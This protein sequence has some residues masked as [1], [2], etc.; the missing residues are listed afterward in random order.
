MK[1]EQ[2]KKTVALLEAKKLRT[3]VLLEASV[4]I[5]R[6]N[7]PSYAKTGVDVISVGRI[8]HSAKSIDMSMEITPEARSKRD[9]VWK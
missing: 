8:T 9:P 3:R 2:V 6:E 7:L 4:G 1:P 5:T